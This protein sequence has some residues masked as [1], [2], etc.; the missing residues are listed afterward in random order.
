MDHATLIAVFIV[1]A[2]VAIVLQML[3][4]LGFLLIFRKA[5]MEARSGYRE[6]KRQIDLVVQTAAD[7][8]TSAREPVKTATANMAEISRI[9]RDR[10]AS[11]DGA[12]GE[13]LEKTRFQ[14]DR[15]DLLVSSLVD[16]VTA[17]ADSIERNVLGPLQRFS[18]LARG[19]QA[20]LDF[21]LSRR[22]PSTAN[23]AKHDEEMFI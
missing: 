7:V 16:R 18:A 9:V 3:L 14:I 19:I 10:A 1:I 6:A 11:I 2:A 12:L 23:E 15:A 17:A 13:A 20:G 8:I 22:R 21:F 5:Y 4:L